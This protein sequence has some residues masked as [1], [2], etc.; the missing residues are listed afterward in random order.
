MMSM[1]LIHRAAN[2]ENI[3]FVSYYSGRERVQ[4]GCSWAVLGY[5]I[6]WLQ[7]APST[8][9]LDLWSNCYAC[10][11]FVAVASN[12]RFCKESET[13]KCHGLIA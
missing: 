4:Y 13:L 10:G 6:K 9:E 7:I 2:I 12:L 5:I 1:S 11:V 3:P 8:I